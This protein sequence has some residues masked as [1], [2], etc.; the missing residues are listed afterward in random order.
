MNAR[1]N[2]RREFEAALPRIR[3]HAR[4]YFRNVVCPQRLSAN[5]ADYLTD[6]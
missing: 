2:C 5:P 3:E 6:A 4:I 1:E